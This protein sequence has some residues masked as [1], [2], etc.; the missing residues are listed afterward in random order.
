LHSLNPSEPDDSSS[1]TAL[2][3]PPAPR[4]A[5][6]AIAEPWKRSWLY[7]ARGES[8][9]LG[10]I[11]LLHASALVG[12]ILIPLLGGSLWPGWQVALAALLLTQLGGLGTTIAYHRA[13]AHGGVKLRGPLEH[14]LIFFAMLNG[15]GRPQTW[16]ANHRLHHATSDTDEDISSPT[17][18]GFWWAHLRWL[19][20]AGQVP[21]AR[22]CPDLDRP[23]Y[24]FWG[25]MQI[26]ILAL[27][28]FGGLAFGVSAWLW[29]GPLRLLWALH[30]QCTINSICH[31]D[32]PK[33][34]GGSSKNVWWLA[35]FH[36]LQGENWHRNHHEQPTD[37]RLG[38]SKLELDFGWWS[39]VVLKW[40][41][42]VSRVRRPRATH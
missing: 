32:D 19:W 40:C 8:A 6:S 35:P 15:S 12:L 37:A 10:W 30:A 22:F 16:V 20:Q 31:F 4:P 1:S 42:L 3:D 26:P 9:T 36:F 34:V 5:C 38:R 18:G 28:F 41:G 7:C 2:L 11:V 29:L 23:A 25:R 13:L 24:R 17:Q 21:V 33:A 27:A 14:V 39:I